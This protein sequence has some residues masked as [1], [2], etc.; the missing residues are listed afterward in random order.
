MNLYRCKECNNNNREEDLVITVNQYGEW[1][2]HCNTCNSTHLEL[3]DE[4]TQS[5]HS[6]K[7]YY[8]L[9]EDL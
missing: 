6:L 9:E 7:T 2:M 3:V 4:L 1:V 8:E 5:P